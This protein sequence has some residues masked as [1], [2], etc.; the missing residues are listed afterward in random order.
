MSDTDAKRSRIKTKIA[1]SQARL[2]RDGEATAPRKRTPQSDASPPEKFSALAR[3]YPLLAMAGG[4][5]VG[6][7]IAALL[8]RSIGRK[9]GRRAAAVATIA[10]ELG[11][12]YGKQAIDAASEAGR[13][14]REKIGELGEVIDDN[15][16]ETRQRAARMVGNAAGNA[17]SAG[18]TLARSAVRLAA[19]ARRRA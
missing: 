19:R 5:A 16:A 14:A 7:V 4:I 2:T 18:L 10:S 1:A 12:L 3:E 6:V 13:E 15:T 17:R 11:A 8:P 9:L